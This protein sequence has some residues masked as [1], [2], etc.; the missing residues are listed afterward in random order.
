MAKHGKHMMGDED[1]PPERPAPIHRKLRK[2]KKKKGGK[3]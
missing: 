3:K 1:M 2:G